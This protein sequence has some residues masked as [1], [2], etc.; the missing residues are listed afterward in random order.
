MLILFSQ[1]SAAAHLA[2]GN[3]ASAQIMRRQCSGVVAQSARLQ[4]IPIPADFVSDLR[5][6]LP[7]PTLPNAAP[8]CTPRLIPGGRTGAY[9]RIR[10]RIGGR[11]NRWEN[12]DARTE[13]QDVVY[14]LPRRGSVQQAFREPGPLL[15]F[16]KCWDSSSFAFVC[17]VAPLRDRDPTMLPS[18]VPGHRH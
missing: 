2:I 9:A 8:L 13:D 16:P 5:R 11:S 3:N 18:T 12:P 14:R 17:V 10:D 1:P 7:P 4:Q 15:M 6:Y